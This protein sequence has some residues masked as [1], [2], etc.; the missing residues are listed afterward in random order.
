MKAGKLMFIALIGCLAVG[1]TGC[2]SWQSQPAEP[3]E[4]PPLVKA[5]VFDFDGI[6]DRRYLVGGGYL[7]HYRAQVAGELFV[8]DEYTDRLLATISLQPGEEHEI[9]Y[10]INDEKLSANLES[11]GIDPKKA[12][13]KI[14]FVPH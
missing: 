5:G 13:I 11:I 6:P 1:I 10:D 8:A 7:I 3:A 4:S 9:E 14:Y 2:Q 12:G